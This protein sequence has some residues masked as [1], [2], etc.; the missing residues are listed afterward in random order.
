M[1]IR[2]IAV[3]ASL[4]LAITISA[5]AAAGDE[6]TLRSPSARVPAN[7]GAARDLIERSFDRAFA[8]REGSAAKVTGKAA[9]QDV[10]YRLINEPLWTQQPACPVVFAGAS[11]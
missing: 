5:T 10:L 3:A 6:Q 8:H 7:N 9:G 1:R 2:N 4:A 11:R